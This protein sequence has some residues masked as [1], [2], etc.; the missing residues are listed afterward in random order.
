MSLS[1]KLLLNWQ[2]T[3]SIKSIPAKNYKPWSI[4]L[5]IAAVAI[6]FFYMH[7]RDHRIADKVYQQLLSIDIQ[8]DQLQESATVIKAE[9]ETN[10]DL[11]QSIKALTKDNIETKKASVIATINKV[12]YNDDVKAQLLSLI[13]ATTSQNFK[14]Q[15]KLIIKQLRELKYQYSL[16]VQQFNNKIDQIT[17]QVAQLKDQVAKIKSDDLQ[18][19]ESAK[20]KF[21]VKKLKTTISDMHE[22]LV[23]EIVDDV[24]DKAESDEIPDDEN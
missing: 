3:M 16:E 14:V 8:L 15:R 5:L 21:I 12:S 10:S 17:A 6:Y 20:L 18:D 13:T 19:L 4:I 2:K 23:T 7:E 9:K 11:A 1:N 22:S 24:I